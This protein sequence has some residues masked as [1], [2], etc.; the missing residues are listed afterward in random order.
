MKTSKDSEIQKIKKHL[1]IE[2]I[3][4]IS[5][6]I[7]KLLDLDIVKKENCE[8]IKKED[9]GK[10]RVSLY[11]RLS[12][13]DGDIIDGDVSKSI[14]NQLLI[15]LDEC[16]KREWKVSAI[17][18]EEGISGTNDNR[19]E[20]KK[21]L[22]YC[23]QG[24]TEIVLCKSQSRFSRNMEMIEK[25]LHNEFI[26]WNV[27]FVGLVDSTD[28]S[29][30]GNKKARQI[31]GL[32][33]EWQVEDQSINI[34]A[35]IKNKQSNGLFTGAFAPYGYKK[36]PK[37]K[38]HLI[39]D[40]E[41]AKI[42]RRIYR[43]FSN[44]KG[45][46]QICRYLNKNKIPIPSIYK[47]EKN[48]NYNNYKV[49][50][51]TNSIYV[52]RTNT[53]YQILKNELYLGTLV[54]HKNETI[55]YKNKKQR[56]ISKEDRIIVPY[57][58]SPIIDKETWNIVNSRFGR[59]KR[60]REISNGEISIF[61]DKIKC[62]CCK[63]KFYRNSKKTKNQTYTYWLCGNRYETTQ[64]LCKNRK[65]IKEEELY[66]IML[67]EIN[68][69]IQKYYDKVLVEKKYHE[70]NSNIFFEREEDL[71]KEKSIINKNLVKKERTLAIIYEDKINKIIDTEEF[72]IIKSKTKMDIEN[73]KIRLNQVENDLQNL[74][75]KK[76]IVKGITESFN[77]K[78]LDKKTLD[79]FISEIYIG[80][81]DVDLQSRKI[82]IKWNIK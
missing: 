38:Y 54:Q 71:E 21:L 73:M 6:D 19:P 26:K 27:R 25:Y 46:T 1:D 20:W 18:C 70:L 9:N 30:L 11:I 5:E 49:N 65:S 14:K 4:Y 55:S 45:A 16:K 82:S 58:H 61:S 31:N 41:S 15:L 80:C 17:F 28:T 57:C 29:V 77:I 32:V 63:H 23:E 52:W 72:L 51:N 76:T 34:R 36:D 10:C 62:S 47:H 81:Y 56:R 7:E 44:G 69:Q 43:M 60:I 12:I 8:K 3:E 39:I 74:R 64:E 33:N 24:K 75:S 78:E 13:E 40:E 59:K 79:E 22:K 2:S 48:A 66:E 67:R 35:I 37:D 50:Q 53:I 68:Q 42:V